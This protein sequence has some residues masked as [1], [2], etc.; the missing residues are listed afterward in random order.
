MKT[1]ALY[2]IIILLL[3]SCQTHNYKRYDD[4]VVIQLKR[5]EDNEAKLLKLRVIADNIIHVTASPSDTFP[6]FKSLV[7]R[8]HSNNSAKWELEQSKN[9]LI[10]KTS[11]IKATISLITG[12]I[13]YSDSAG[14][15]LL[16]EQHGGGKTFE[17]VSV[18]DK[19][20]YNIKQVFPFFWPL[21]PH[22]D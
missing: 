17:P 8:N 2:I 21:L 13:M 10:L 3:A 5:P 18:D 11:S 15:V 20:F 19:Q 14:N 4:N 1:N 12:E 16:R 22:E 7:T 6:A 9:N